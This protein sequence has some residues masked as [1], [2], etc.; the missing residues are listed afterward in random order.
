MPTMFSNN[1]TQWCHN[2]WLIVTRIVDISI[3]TI[4]I[5]A[6]II[7]IYGRYELT[8]FFCYFWFVFSY[9]RDLILKV[10]TKIK[11]TWFYNRPIQSKRNAD[12][13][14]VREFRHVKCV[15]GRISVRVHVF[16]WFPLM[17]AAFT[18]TLEA[19]A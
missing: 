18:H 19:F 2:C 11:D 4:V 15:Q 7:W 9:M 8:A 16:I 3:M 6:S 17:F 10:N 14:C 12:Y 5:W 1:T 13:I